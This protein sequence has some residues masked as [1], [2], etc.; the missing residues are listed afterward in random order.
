MDTMEQSKTERTYWELP[1]DQFDI[2][3]LPMEAYFKIKDKEREML[4]ESTFASDRGPTEAED[5]Y[6]E[7][8]QREYLETE[9]SRKIAEE[10]EKG[11]EKGIVVPLGMRQRAV[12]EGEGGKAKKKCKAK[13]KRQLLLSKLAMEQKVDHA[14]QWSFLQWD[15]KAENTV[16]LAWKRNKHMYEI[17][18]EAK[19]REARKHTK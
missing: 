7:R 5:V 8:K 13:Y 4:I 15:Q 11:L 17:E 3:R 10:I 1:M 12:R 18:K 19:K 16:R 2:H 6:Q 9:R 14:E